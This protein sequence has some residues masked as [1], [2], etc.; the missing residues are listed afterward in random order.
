MS[1]SVYHV[2]SPLSHVSDESICGY[3]KKIEERLGDEIKIVTASELANEPLNLVFIASGGSEGVFLK[4]YQKFK[5]RPVYII[6]SGENNSLAASMEILSYLQSHDEN[7]EILHGSI[8]RVAKRI[9]ALTRAYAAKKA[10]NGKR[11]GLIGESS[12]WLIASSDSDKKYREK[13]NVSLIK[14]GMDELLSEI[15]VGGYPDNVYTRDL[16]S[17]GYDSK[18]MEKALN[19][20]GALKRI[21]ERYGLMGVTVRCFDLLDT[22]YTTGCLG[23]AILNAEGIYAG[24]EGDVPALMSMAILGE[25][26]QKPVFLCNPSRIEED[27]GEMVLAHC[28]L[29]INMPDSYS[30]MTHYESGIG[31]ALRGHIPEEVCTIFKISANLDTYYAKCGEIV[32]NLSEASL[33]RTQIRLKLDDFYYFTECPI[34]NHH[35]IALGD[36]EEALDVFFDLIND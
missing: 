35:L 36:Y 2:K 12:N 17:K 1:V 26:S 20:Y 3:L 33:C 23:L 25:V 34:N 24:C 27:K 22:V 10:L 7:G 6:T 16:L 30:L 31:V 13:L 4:E 19:V 28:T 29:P 5:G 8:E 9:K 21:V 15:A 11:I 18:E 32:G 14:I